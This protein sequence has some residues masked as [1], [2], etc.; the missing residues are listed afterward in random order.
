ML[1]GLEYLTAYQAAQAKCQE[2]NGLNF[3]KN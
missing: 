2:I 3:E 1:G